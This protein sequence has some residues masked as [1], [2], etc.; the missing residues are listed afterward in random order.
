MCKCG[1]KGL[2]NNFCLELVI[3]HELI[4]SLTVRKKAKHY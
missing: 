4:F 2:H 1:E 3:K